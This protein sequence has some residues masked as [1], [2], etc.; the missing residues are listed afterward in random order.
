M[1][2]RTDLI[3][4]DQQVFRKVV[5]TCSVTTALDVYEQHIKL[6]LTC[7]KT[8]GVVDET[9][10]MPDQNPVDLDSRSSRVCK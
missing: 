9:R 5:P 7:C 1:F 4:A 3:R 10:T 2:E 8:E 6:G